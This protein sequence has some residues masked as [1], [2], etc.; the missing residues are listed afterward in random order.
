MRLAAF[1]LALAGIA[2]IASPAVAGVPP[3]AAAKSKSAMEA[4]TPPNMD[5]VMAVFNKLLPPQPEPD[6]ARLALA[7][8]SAAAMWPEGAYCDMM[9]GFAGNMVDNVMRLK[10]SDLP[11]PADKKTKADATAD[12]SLHDAAAAKDPYFDQR[13]AA[14]RAAVTDEF[15]KISAVI[16][17]RVRD[18]MARAMARRFDARQLTDINAFL[19]T[20]T[21]RAFGAQYMQ[22]WLDPDMM[23]G[24]IGSMPEMI[25]LMPDIMKS[26]KD[27]NDKFPAP[28]ASE[29]RKPARS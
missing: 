20:P 15:G 6:P 22:L 19:V 13:M 9:T 23:R 27:A 5:A 14:I 26:I 4:M 17:P 12:L 16:D 24:M 1:S 10:K 28:P 18:G 11:I 25:K 8:T 29:K 3:K 7:R 2:V 21:G